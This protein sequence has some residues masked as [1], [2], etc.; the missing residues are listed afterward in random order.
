MAERDALA[1]VTGYGSDAFSQEASSKGFA[2]MSQE[3]ADELNGR[4]TALQIAG[5][6]VRANMLQVVAHLGG[7]SAVS[8]ENNALLSQVRD[9]VITSNSFLENIDANTALMLKSFDAK[10]NTIVDNTN[11]L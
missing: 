10:L 5:E 11:R 9:V 8:A 2:S 4:F 7:L 6:D 1:S 3:T